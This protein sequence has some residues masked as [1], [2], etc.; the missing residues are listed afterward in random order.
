MRSSI[1]F[2]IT[3]AYIYGFK[4]IRFLH[5]Y[6]QGRNNYMQK[7]RML[8]VL[9]FT[10]ASL[11]LACGGLSSRQKTATNEAIAALRK[12]EAGT[13]VGVRYQEVGSLVIDA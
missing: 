12:I 10:V 2:K 3:S 11:S 5:P 9:A 1:I 4:L 13:Q 8:F 7:R 6:F